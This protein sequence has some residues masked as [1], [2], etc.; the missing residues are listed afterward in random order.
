MRRAKIRVN[1]RNTKMNKRENPKVLGD[2]IDQA[3]EAKGLTTPQ[4]AK[5]VSVHEATDR[6]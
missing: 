3:R 5:L 6:R 1:K 4:L 2:T